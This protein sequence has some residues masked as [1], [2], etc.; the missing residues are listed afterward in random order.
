[1]KVTKNMKKENKVVL[2]IDQ[3]IVSIVKL[4]RGVTV[5]VRD[6]DIEAADLEDLKSD[7]DGGVYFL[8]NV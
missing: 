4:P 5:E 7:A 6:Y 2:R 3:G 8:Q 1:M